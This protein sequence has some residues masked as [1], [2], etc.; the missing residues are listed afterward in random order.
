MKLDD[1]NIDQLFRDA[2]QN[3]SAPNYDSSYWNDVSSVLNAEDR[4]KKLLLFWS[5]G[6]SLALVLLFSMLF[7]GTNGD[8][9]IMYTQVE[10]NDVKTIKHSDNIVD[11]TSTK[12]KNTGNS[13]SGFNS[14][15]SVKEKINTPLE[16]ENLQVHNVSRLFAQADNNPGNELTN[17]PKE[18]N[19]TTDKVIEQNIPKNDLS[20]TH[21]DLTD[22][23]LSLR[24]KELQFDIINTPD[25]LTLNNENNWNVLIELNA[26]IM[27][28]YKTSRPFESGLVSL[29]LKGIYSK[30]NLILSSGIG[31][32]ASTN[33][34][35]V[36][37]QRAKF[38]GFG[39]VNYQTDLSYQNMYDIY[40]PLEIGYKQNK[41]SFGMGLQ[42]NYLI[43][44]SMMM[45]KYEDNE[46]ISTENITGYSNWLN[47]LSAQGYVW[48][49]H[50]LGDH[51]SAGLK[52]GT[53]F[54]NR[55]K[56][57][58]YFNE[59]S[60]TNPVFGQ[61]SLRYNIFK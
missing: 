24:M 58:D 3:A 52:I 27:E 29:A 18:M 10:S 42:A 12:P 60:T 59:S 35:L 21:L 13:S 15:R 41:T 49:S 8:Q 28:N 30:S 48:L 54:T 34:D 46:L 14:S 2:A 43:N 1:K 9:S 11:V 45:Q 61:V 51:F 4:K 56:E 36:V 26:G 22:E 17:T 23:N 7:T 50:Q 6:G 38:Y 40:I 33:S 16:E 37:S 53:S 39:V 57:G 19:V 5:L 31:L 44:T 32:Q 20:S 25:L 55:I 47:K